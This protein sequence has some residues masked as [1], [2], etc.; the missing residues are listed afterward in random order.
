[1]TWKNIA[2]YLA[3][4]TNSLVAWCTAQWGMN[5]VFESPQ[6]PTYCKRERERERG[7]GDIA[8]CDWLLVG[9]FKILKFVAK[10]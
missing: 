4:Q 5:P 1:M 6:P 8:S 9:H 3:K 2:Q 7:E 10:T